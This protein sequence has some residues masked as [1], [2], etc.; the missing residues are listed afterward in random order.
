MGCCVGWA[1]R[2][3][4]PLASRPEHGCGDGGGP[5]HQL[6]S[7]AAPFPLDVGRP[8][9]EGLH[10]RAY[11]CLHYHMHSLPIQGVIGR[12]RSEE[13]H[14]RTH[15]CLYYQMPCVEVWLALKVIP[16]LPRLCTTLLRAAIVICYP[17]L[18]VALAE[19]VAAYTTTQCT[20]LQ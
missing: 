10:D 5:Q 13:L 11:C 16:S 15:C 7:S 9:S 3:R 1:P 14:G 4:R 20:A 19:R 17:R 6:R 2:S 8:K 18:A 12:T